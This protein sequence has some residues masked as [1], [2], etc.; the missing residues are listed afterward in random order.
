MKKEDMK[1]L[2]CE[3]TAGLKIELNKCVPLAEFSFLLI[4]FFFPLNNIYSQ[5]P[6][7][8]FCKYNH[9]KTDSAFTGIFA[10]NFNKDSY[11]DLI[12]F[13]PSRKQILSLSGNHSGNFNTNKP[14]NTPLELSGISGITDRNNRVTGFAFSSRKSMK[15]GTLEF[16]KD[17]RIRI[18]AE[19]KFSSYPEKINTADINGDGINEILVSG[20]VFDGL[21]VLIPSSRNIEEHK[22][23]SGTSYST[24]VFGD[25]SNDGFADIAAAN[26]YSNSIDLFYNNGQGNFKKV[27]SIPNGGSYFLDAFDMNLDYYEDLVYSNSNGITILYGDPSS[28][29]EEKTV[30]K[31]EYTPHKIITGDFNKDGRIDIIYADFNEE[32][33]SVI[34]AKNEYEFY[35]EIFY[36]KKKGI[37]DILPFYSRFISGA[38]VLSELGEIYTITHL[39]SF[40]G[41]VNI[42]IGIEP[43]ALEYFDNDNN[44]ITDISFIDNF[45][46]KLKFILRNPAGIPSYFFSYPLY[47][48]HSDILVDNRL[49]EIKTF[50][51]YS[52]GKRLIETITADFNTNKFSRQ[53]LYSPGAIKDLKIS[54]AGGNT[55]IYSAYIKDQQLGLSVFSYHDF[56]FTSSDYFGIA[57]N[58]SSV[59]ISVNGGVPSLLYW[60]VENGRITLSKYSVED[61]SSKQVINASLPGGKISS[62]TSFVGDLL[63]MEKDVSIS[64]FNAE[65][66]NHVIISTE[67]MTRILQAENIEKSFAIPHKK[68]LYFGETRVNGLKKLMLY[69]PKNNNIS[70]I[71]FINRGRNLIT[72]KIAAVNSPA[73]FFVK[74]MSYK[75][76]HVVYSNKAENC[77]T[78][79]EI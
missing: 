65:R 28:S 13:N 4:L 31:T 6:I 57:K 74:N 54:S 69:N 68:E 11:T 3:E 41:E 78:I 67:D 15:A 12:L 76:Y 23:I 5:I 71:D 40:S 52:P 61:K 75:K 35:P 70:R 34:F 56:R 48:I 46:S 9:F 2:C 32:I 64:F 59:N 17:G 43:A 14:Y 77:I 55:R 66:N 22:I 19:K 72:T 25:I 1:R 7:N 44:S 33:V 51:C 38:A 16:L 49:P 24:A 53:S 47:E 36:M 37:K 60:Q 18:L 73:D 8:G 79:K 20:S 26:I 30:I 42:S 21:S 58:S 10:A 63:N 45:D 27:R 62:V 29:F 39:T 50:Y